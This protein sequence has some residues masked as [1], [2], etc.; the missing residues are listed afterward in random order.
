MTLADIEVRT[1]MP[2]DGN[3]LPGAA[4]A[5]S[6]AGETLVTLEMHDCEVDESVPGRQIAYLFEREPKLPAIIVRG[7]S[8]GDATSMVSR[9]GFFQQLSSTFGRELCMPRPIGYLLRIIKDRPLR[10][11]AT[12][13]IVTATR[14]AL[15]RPAHLV[16]EPLLV[17]FPGGALRTLDMHVLL[18]G[19]TRVLAAAQ[20]AMVQSEKLAGLGQLAAGMAHEVNNPLAFVINNVAVAQRDLRA[21]LDVLELYVS[22]D[23]L[24]G[25]RMPELSES[26]CELAERIDLPYTAENLPVLM[27][28]TIDGLRRIQRI[29]QDLRNFA[30]LDES[31][32]HEVDLND[33]ITST[34]NI[35][36][37]SAR[38]RG[39]E[40]ALELAGHL[41]RVACYPAKLNQVVMNLLTNAID[42]SPSGAR[43]VVRTEDAGDA[44]RVEVI[45]AGAGIDAATRQRIFEPFFTTKP[46]G[47]GMGLG[48]SISYSIVRD[49]AGTIKVDSA[50]GRGSTFTVTIPK[51]ADP[52]AAQRAKG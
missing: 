52:P 40:V 50:P 7:S 48:L 12:T 22:A 17:E 5:A 42:A 6:G 8:D 2:S 29:V 9:A 45:D 15:E 39:V 4:G 38:D 13:A 47:K 37:G 14:A 32:W 10:V 20:A 18:L 21:L 41:P 36:R 33:G 16:Y 43:V 27:K 44:V 24:L 49:H 31:D 51:R 25:E 26:I 34:A 46:V 1:N 3:A 28:S 11:P 23:A 19:Q 30:R 35:V